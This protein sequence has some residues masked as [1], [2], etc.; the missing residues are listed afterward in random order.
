[1]LWCNT[2]LLDE[3]TAEPVYFLKQPKNVEGISSTL[4]FFEKGVSRMI[5]N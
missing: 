1:M 5:E 3:C 4:N 2:I